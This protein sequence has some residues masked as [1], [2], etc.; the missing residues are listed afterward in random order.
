MKKHWGLFWQFRKAHLMRQMEYR[1]D[2]WFWSLVSAVWTGFN[3]FFF[4]MIFNVSGG[5]GGWNLAEMYLLLATFNIMDSFTWSFFYHNMSHYTEAIFSGELSQWL[6]KPVN[7]QFLLMTQSNSYS[8]ISRFLIGCAM[9]GWSIHQLQLALNPFNIIGYLCALVISSAFIYFTWFLV[10]TCAFWVEKLE[11]INEIVPI[12]RRVYQVPASVYTGI[13][14]FVFTVL[15]PF[16]LL[17]SVPSEIL[18]N[19]FSWK[20]LIYLSLFTG[21]L[22][23]L[24]HWFLKISI[25]K[26]SSVGN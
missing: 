4:S 9:L 7:L 2:F 13:S 23:L 10:A 17:S 11:N 8:N 18:L 5:I 22:I 25:K 6:V 19:T 15:L 16:G 21:G 14:S 24:S 3:V 1:A 20:S 26:Y 12:M